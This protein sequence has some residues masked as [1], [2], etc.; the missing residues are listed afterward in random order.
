MAQPTSLILCVVGVVFAAPFQ[1]SAGIS[2][3]I[4]QSAISHDFYIYMEFNTPPF[5]ESLLDPS[6][7]YYKS[8]KSDFVQLMEDVYWCPDCPTKSFYGGATD[9]TFSKS[10]LSTVVRMTLGFRTQTINSILVKFVFIDAFVQS[11]KKPNIQNIR[12]ER[13]DQSPTA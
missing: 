5:E 7:D 8:L 12:V 11:P 13:V 4:Q 10:G 9:V 1:V 6:S 2:A 3:N